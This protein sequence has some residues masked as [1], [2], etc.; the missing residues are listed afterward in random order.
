MDNCSLPSSSSTVSSNR[1]IGDVL[2]LKALKSSWPLPAQGRLWPIKAGEKDEP[3]RDRGG[4]RIRRRNREAERKMGRQSEERKE[5]VQKKTEERKQCWNSPSTLSSSF[6]AAS[7]RFQR[8]GE[9]RDREG[10][11]EDRENKK[12]QRE[13]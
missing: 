3:R 5:R 12:K 11:E 4:K 10:E 1:N 6:A 2:S 7:S 8:Q 13:T 9:R